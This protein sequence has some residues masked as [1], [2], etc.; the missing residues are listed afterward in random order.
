VGSEP[1]ADPT[2]EDKQMVIDLIKAYARY[3]AEVSGLRYNLYI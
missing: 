1:A 2:A 3:E